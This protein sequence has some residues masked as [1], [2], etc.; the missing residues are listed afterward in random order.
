MSKSKLQVTVI[1]ADSPFKL[2]DIRELISY[3]DL[4]ITMSWRD[5]RVKY[6]QT[7]IGFLWALINPLFSLLILHFI[8]GRVI[9]VDTGGVPH[10]VFTMIGLSIW[11]Y[12]STLVSESGN[13]ILSNQNMIKKIYFPKIILP[14]SKALT[15]LVDYIIALILLIVVM[16]YV[17]YTPSSHIVYVP[18]FLFMTIFTGITAGIWISAMTVRYRDFKFVVPFI[19]QLGLYASP[20]AYSSEMVPESY[21]FL[22]HCNPLVGIIEGLRWS[23]TGIGSLNNSVWYTIISIGIFFIVGLWLF[24]RVEHKMA[25]I[26]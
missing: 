21:Q 22:Y 16:I 10:L 7:F 23:L 6:A 25:D 11:T 26:L 5:L 18:F 9:Q 20:I 14:L 3:R 12:F 4:I 13:S 8:F 24:R 15:G 1:E 2:L 17:D 19:L